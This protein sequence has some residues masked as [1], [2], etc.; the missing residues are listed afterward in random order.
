MRILAIIPARGGSM[1][2]PNKNIIETAGK[3]L[4]V[5]SIDAALRS[6]GIERTVVSTDSTEIAAISE[7]NG[8][9]VIIR[10]ADLAQNETPTLPVI[11]HALA[12]LSKQNYTPDAVATLQPTSP[13]RTDKHIEEAIELFSNDPTA[14]SLVSCMR[15][16]HIFHPRSVMRITDAGYLEP[17]LKKPQPLRRQDKDLTFARNGA[18]I[19]I[20]RTNCLREFI[21]GGRLIPYEMNAMDSCDIDGPE[22]LTHAEAALLAKL[23]SERGYQS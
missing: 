22:D 15:V 8:A 14:D 19:Y 3:P 23:K 2:I 6:R 11:Q 20:T 16:P 12:E 4:I 9:E 17:Y 18:A 1:G 21:F 13:L 10:P 7:K 5:W